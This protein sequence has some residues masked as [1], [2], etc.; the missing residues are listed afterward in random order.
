MKYVGSLFSKMAAY[1]VALLVAQSAASALA[2]Q[3]EGKAVVRAIRGSAQYS[4]GGEWLV[5]KQGKVLTAGAVIKT[6]V[7]SQVDLDIKKNGPIVRVTADTVLALDSLKF[8]ETGTGETVIET[9]L[10]LTSGRILGSVNPLAAA[11]K[12]EVKIPSG[13]VGIRGTEYDISANGVVS[14]NSGS[15]NVGYMVGNAMQN[16]IVNA[17]QTFTPATTPGGP[18]VTS[19]LTPELTTFLQDQFKEIQ[20]LIDETSGDKGGGGN[21]KKGTVPI[22]DPPVDPRTSPN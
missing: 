1:G 21:V 9:K 11:S 20:A 7:G 2:E 4:Q 10:N 17:G 16:F 22:T 5:L 6:A 19:A 8:E 18:P 3:Q 15:A 13:T 14:L 12:Y